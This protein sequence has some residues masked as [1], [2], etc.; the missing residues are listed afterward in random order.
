MRWLLA[1]LVLA[2]PAKAQEQAPFALRLQASPQ[3]PVWIGQRV[4]VTL[5]ALTPVRFTTPLRFPE[6]QPQGRAIVLPEGSTTPGSER[7][8]GMTY[9]AIQHSYELFPAEAGTITLPPIRLSARVG[10]GTDATAEV[11]A[12]RIEAR[13]PP[14]VT[15]LSRLVVAPEFR[16][17]ATT[18]RAPEGLRVGE[19]IT[20][21][22]RLEAR[23]T[24][25]MLL[26]VALWGQPE[27]VA[28]YPS[29]PELRDS[30]DRGN[31]RATRQEH[32]SYVP[33]RAGPVELPGFSVFWFE[34]RA[35]RMQELKVEPI[36]FEALP[37]AEATS[38]APGAMAWLP[39]LGA[40][41]LA[42]ALAAVAWLFWRRRRG[43]PNPEREALAALR[44]ACRA[45][46]A[47]AAF[48]AL[49][50]WRDTLLPSTRT[51][52]AGIVPLRNEAQHLEDTLYAKPPAA[53]WTG[54][55]LLRA[56]GTAR[57]RLRHRHS[58]G[59]EPSALP[60]L[61]PGPAGPP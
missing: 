38:R 21:S 23:D 20:R 57:R 32:A 36:R 39:W 15:D 26:P 42:L 59:A 46:R 28:V 5:T 3:G 31:L 35:G 48:A 44:A 17:T 27:G 2:A 51:A 49:Y 25:S 9:A 40:V 30:T 13:A 41:L 8:G 54:A 18:D 56:V 61:N 22:L 37:A 55:A 12:L 52:T 1:L 45:D 6:L 29:P 4:T 14:G 43:R 10:D 11:A 19:A 53:P 58:P 60:A 50:R 34:P 33:Q 47:R 7:I 24:S 16:L